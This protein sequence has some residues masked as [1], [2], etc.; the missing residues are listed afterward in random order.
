VSDW[1]LEQTT[2]SGRFVLKSRYA[3]Y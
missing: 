1:D 3:L 2:S